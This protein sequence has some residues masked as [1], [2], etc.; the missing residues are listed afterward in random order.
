MKIACA[1][2][3]NPQDGDGIIRTGEE[4]AFG[5]SNDNNACA[6][7]CKAS[8]RGNGHLY[9]FMK[10]CDDGIMDDA[11]DCTNNCKLPKCDAQIVQSGKQQIVLKVDV[12][13]D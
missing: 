11:D 5:N 4:C 8:V 12:S 9:P 2:S 1:R 10:K 13:C 7:L 6:Q 3:F